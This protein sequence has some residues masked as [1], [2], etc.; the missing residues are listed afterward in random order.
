[1]LLF[2]LPHFPLHPKCLQLGAPC[3]WRT[4]HF[5]APFSP[6]VSAPTSHPCSHLPRSRLRHH[7]LTAQCEVKLSPFIILHSFLPRQCHA[8]KL[9]P[10]VPLSVTLR[11]NSRNTTFLCLSLLQPLLHPNTE[12]R[13]VLLMLRTILRF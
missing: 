8:A 1:M 9:G 10:Q 3:R 7:S 11:R 2:V 13:N 12:K 5:S 6:S 4:P